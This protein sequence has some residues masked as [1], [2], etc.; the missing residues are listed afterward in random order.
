MHEG[1]QRDPRFQLVVKYNKTSK[2]DVRWQCGL[3]FTVATRPNEIMLSW[4]Q[5]ERESVGFRI[6]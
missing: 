6:A 2:L 3:S 1:E 5:R 4:T